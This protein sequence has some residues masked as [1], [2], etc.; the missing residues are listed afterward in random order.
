LF[1]RRDEYRGEL[2]LVKGDDGFVVVGLRSVSL[3]SSLDVNYSIQAESLIKMELWRNGR[4][5]PI[6]ASIVINARI[7]AK[8]EVMLLGQEW[9]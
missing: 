7:V 5:V 1:H 6:N 4:L 8:P 9:R 3:M 2:C